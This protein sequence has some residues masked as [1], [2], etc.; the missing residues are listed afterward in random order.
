MIPEAD[1][2]TALYERLSRD[3]DLQGDSNSITNQKT[4]LEDFCSQRGLK[5]LRH[6][7]DDGYSGGN[8]DRPSWKRMIA[9]AEAG[10]IDVIVAK[11]MSRIGRNYLEVG[12]YTQVKFRE[13]GIRF[14]AIGN[15][16]DTNV[17]G[18][19]DFMPF[20][21]IFNEMN[22][23]DCSRKIKA[24]LHTKG[25]SGKHLT[26]NVIYGYKKDE[27]DP[28]HWVIDEEAAAVVRRIFKMTIEGIG[29]YKIATRLMNDKVERPSYYLWKRG[30]GNLK[31]ICDTAH[32]YH[33]NGATVVQILAHPEY[34]GCTVNFRTSSVSYKTKEQKRNDPS[35]WVI[36]EDTQE[37][38]VDKETW[39]LAQKLRQTKRRTDTTGEANPLT[40]LVYCSDCGERMYNHRG[41]GAKLKSDPSKRGKPKD[42]YGCSTYFSSL[43]HHIHACSPHHIRTEVLREIILYAIRSTAQIAL[44]DEEGFRKKVLAL[45]DLQR[46]DDAKALSQKLERDRARCRELDTLI[47]NLFEA[48]V[49]GRLTNKRFAMLSETY[50]K[51][52][53]ELERSISESEEKL[54]QFDEDEVNIDHFL[55]LAKKYDDFSELTTPM[56]NEFIEKIIVHEAEKI[57]G[58]RTQEVEVCLKYIGRFDL[59]QREPTA[60]ELAAEEKRKARRANNREKA[61][62]CY[63]KKKQRESAD[64]GSDGAA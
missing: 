21:N 8:F 60:E 54:A 28:H 58:E 47:Q 36:F 13:L 35:E 64:G 25:M 61:N 20:V 23:R 37:P 24:V 22:L 18:S 52:Q 27:N 10:R 48:N 39:E 1:K 62:R 17:A 43:C 44:S 57:D 59:P 53:G 55:K 34:M 45:H 31:S 49:T 29:P 46:K 9:D 50:E 33:W 56:L 3:D 4:M 7:T 51:E 42:S 19:D 15:N 6:Y 41:P 14:I 32:P 40:G 38:I 26:A 30:L 11:D 63:H 2:V 16:V 12:Y 5:N